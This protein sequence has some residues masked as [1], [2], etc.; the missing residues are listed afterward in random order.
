MNES[1]VSAYLSALGAMVSGPKALVRRAALEA[2][3]LD[4]SVDVSEDRLRGYVADCDVNDE[5]R[6]ELHL[7]LA[8]WDNAPIEDGLWMRDTRPNTGVRRARIMEL[9]ALSEKTAAEFSTQFSIAE[10]ET[11]IAGEWEP[12]YTADV[13][14]KRDF[15]WGHYIGYLRTRRNWGAS[16]I[17]A[18]DT[19]TSRVVERLTDPSQT[20]PAQTKGL[21]VGYVQSGKTANFAGVIAKSIDAGY[22]LII[23]MTG[24][25][26]LL[27][28]QTQRRLDMELVGR[29]NILRGADENGPDAAQRIDYL[30]DQDWIDDRFNRY[31]VRPTAV[32][33]PE[34]RRMT[35]RRFDYR[36]LQQGL[37]ALEFERADKS[38]PLWHPDNLYSTDARLIVVKKNA[39]VLKN[40]VA[41]LKSNADRLDDI[42]ALIIDD[43][44]DQASINTVDPDKQPADA[45]K[46]RTAINERISTLL[47]MLPRAQYVGY[48]AT[49]FANV[50]ADFTDKNDIFPSNYILALRRPFGYMGV[51][52]FHDIDSSV[53]ESERTFVNSKEKAHVRLLGDGD[54]EQELRRAL[55]SFVLAGAIKLYR[56]QL[57]INDYKHHTMLVHEAAKKANH[58]LRRE[59]VRELWRTADYYRSAG[60]RRLQ[61]LFDQDFVPVSHGLSLGYPM[62]S[63]FAELEPLI[64]QVVRE[65]AP[66]GD[67]VLVINSDNKEL[68]QEE[69]DFDRRPV[70]RILVGG[71]KLARGF[72]VEGLTITYYAR[73][74]GHAEAL[75]Q[76]GRWFGFR[77]GY[78]DLVRLFITPKIRDSFEAACRDEEQFREE[79][80]QFAVMADGRPLVTPEEIQPLVARHGLRP[81]AANKMRYTRLVERRS[82]S[83]EPS[84]GYPTLTESAKLKNNITA[85]TPLLRAASTPENLTTATGRRF[86][87][88]TGRVTQ[89][90]M[91]KALKQ[92]QWRHD[93]T[94]KPDLAWIEGL[95]EEHID[96]WIVV[97]PQ[98]KRRI[99]IRGLGEF[100]LHGRKIE[101]D[102]VRGN[103]E[104]LHREALASLAD[105][106][107]MT[108]CVI[109]YPVI[110]KERGNEVLIEGEWPEGVVMALRLELPER[111]LPVG[112]KPLIYK[113]V[114]KRLPT[115]NT[116]SW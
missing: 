73:S 102:S 89:A 115:A 32:G 74:V 112:T 99:T 57:G 116:E 28:E 5:L 80:R 84:S 114:V 54:D 25:T 103:S 29:E 40:L 34:I 82:R 22:R 50:F 85:V 13:Q 104:S 81:T 26:N 4:P 36:S 67:P 72:T 51:E 92:L 70:W 77:P 37:P 62:P 100:S 53:P 96:H 35:T 71:N 27:R 3:D 8:K 69:L 6:V 79:L 111:A 21:V 88:L 58:K 75:M 113:S 11:L 76:M 90:E 47:R 101:N 20:L 19:A 41:D 16:A 39:T 107:S 64:G 83:K 42:P 106:T 91:V 1:F 15:Y 56:R 30:D 9:L 10:N 78:R 2:E 52:D 98:S 49:P 55:D 109:L 18:L 23:V 94:F 38:K 110:D 7:R 87:A 59:A 60:L 43:E 93:D 44:S 95:G 105:R 48:T 63:S 61:S 97:L 86:D 31:G 24:T 68:D 66:N 12:W 46:E 65:I 17:T 108:A 45:E 14:R 33:K